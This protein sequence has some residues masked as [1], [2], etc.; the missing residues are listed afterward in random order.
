MTKIFRADERRFEA[1]PGRKDGF[2]LMTDATITNG[3]TAARGTETGGG[4]AGNARGAETSASTAG[5]AGGATGAST[6]RNASAPDV[7]GRG[8]LNFDIRQLPP[9]EFSSLYHFHR[10]AEELF[11]ITEGTATL[12]TPDGLHVLK[13][14]DI[15]FFGTGAEG[16]HQLYNHSGEPC[17]YLDIRTF[18]GA[19]IAEYP[20]SGRLLVVPTMERFD[21]AAGTGYF[22][23]EPSAAELRKIFNVK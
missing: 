20:D 2:S 3:M 10:H 9:G 19:D 7:L 13:A 21:K 4:S 6:A 17:V 14:G 11:M 23:G 5:N 22:E 8:S 16:A 18:P 1:N 12:R 15:A